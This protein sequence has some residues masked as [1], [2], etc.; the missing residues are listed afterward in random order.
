[1]LA[2]ARTAGTVAKP[3]TPA[4]SAPAPVTTTVKEN[5]N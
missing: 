1:M 4:L 2:S 3:A 5:I